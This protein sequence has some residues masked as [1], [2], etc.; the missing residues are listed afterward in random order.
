MTRSHW[1]AMERP[2]IEINGVSAAFGRP[3]GL[4]SLDLELPG[5]LTF[6]LGPNGAGKT[7]LL[8]LVA[9]VAVPDLGGLRIL[10]YDPTRSAGRLAV[11]RRLG[12]VPQGLEPYPHLSV[13]GLVDY[14]ALLKELVERRARQ[15]EVH[16]VLEL[17]GLGDVAGERTRDLPPPLW[18]R[19]A[20]ALALTG[21]P[22][23]VVLDDIADRLGPADRADLIELVVEAAADRT[24]LLS[25]RKPADVDVPGAHVV[26][27]HDGLV[28]F[29]GPPE[30]L[31][32]LAEDKVW[33]S[34]RPLAGTHSWWRDAD[35]WVRNVGIPPDPADAVE[36]TVVDGNLLLV[37]SVPIEEVAA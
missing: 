12:Y 1:R 22:D 30:M 11:R 34:E 16:R 8:R 18:P 15:V 24:V 25:T 17:V 20:L 31:A 27:L 35:G 36:P 10:G 6:V 32:G 14:V 3:G 23:L 37:G 2:V 9:T 33:L 21:D 28:H 4:S 29:D 19:M 26:V 7:T 13:F 5:G